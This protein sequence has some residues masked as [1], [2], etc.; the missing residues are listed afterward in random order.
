IHVRQS[1]M[2]GSESNGEFVEGGARVRR[3]RLLTRRFGSTHWAMGFK[4]WTAWAARFAA[5]ATSTSVLRCDLPRTPPACPRRTR[6]A[7]HALYGLQMLVRP[8]LAVAG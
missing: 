1:V 4:T 6:N 5:C 3:L 2:P 7:R 8:V